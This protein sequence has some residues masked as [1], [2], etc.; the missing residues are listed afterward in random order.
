MCPTSLKLLE[1]FDRCGLSLA[2]TNECDD[3][4][5]GAIAH[6]A[7]PTIQSPLHIMVVEDVQD[8]LVVECIQ[9]WSLDSCNR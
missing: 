7:Q 2:D 3:M 8:Q 6:D 9:R 5:R 1:A 4:E